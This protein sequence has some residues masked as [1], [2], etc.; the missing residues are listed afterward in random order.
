MSIFLQRKKRPKTTK[1]LEMHRNSRT[2]HTPEWKI[3]GYFSIG[4]DLAHSLLENSESIKPSLL[5]IY[6]LCWKHPEILLHHRKLLLQKWFKA[7][8]L[9]VGLFPATKA[10]EITGTWF[11]FYWSQG[12]DPCKSPG[13]TI[14]GW[15]EKL[16]CLQVIAQ[17][18]L[19]GWE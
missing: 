11:K 1:P 12:K 18:I 4:K 16:F 19:P 5:W 8:S 15:V 14:L 7:A 13:A 3:Q 17:K 2:C 6:S 10:G 9:R